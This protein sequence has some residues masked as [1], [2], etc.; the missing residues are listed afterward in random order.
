MI[1]ALETENMLIYALETEYMLIYALKTEMP[2]E[3]RKEMQDIVQPKE[4]IAITMCRFYEVTYYTF[5]FTQ[6]NRTFQHF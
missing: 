1:Y 2:Y 4:H 3:K 5:Y 6:L